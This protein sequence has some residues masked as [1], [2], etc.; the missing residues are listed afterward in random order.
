MLGKMCN[1]LIYIRYNLID[2]ILCFYKESSPEVLQWVNYI[3]FSVASGIFAYKSIFFPISALV[4]VCDESLCNWA[5]I[6]A[7]PVSF[8]VFISASYEL[9]PRGK[10][11][12]ARMAVFAGIT[13]VLV[14]IAQNR[15][16][17][18]A[19]KSPFIDIDDFCSLVGCYLS[20]PAIYYAYK[21]KRS[22]HSL[23]KAPKD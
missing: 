23:E 4:P 15:F 16:C 18:F 20:F 2:S 17:V 9:A 7:L 5:V 10:I 21:R 6:I 12:F 19:K 14:H 1:I 3:P 8:Y 11:A 13:F 22:L